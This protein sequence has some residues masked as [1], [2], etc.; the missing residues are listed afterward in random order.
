[1]RGFEEIRF[2]HIPRSENEHSDRLSRLSHTGE[3]EW[4]E[5]VYVDVRDKPDHEVN[6]IYVTENEMEDWRSATWKYLA[7]EIFPMD[8]TKTRKIQARSL[9]YVIRD[10]ELYRLSFSGLLLKCVASEDTSKVL[11]EVHE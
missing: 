8:K 4:P 2:Q 1:M 10:G 11:E 3:G 5:W 7:E 6:S 9:R